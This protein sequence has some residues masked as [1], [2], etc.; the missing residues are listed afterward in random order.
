MHLTHPFYAG[1]KRMKFLSQLKLVEKY[2]VGPLFSSMNGSKP[3]WHTNKEDNSGEY[4]F[5]NRHRGKN[6]KN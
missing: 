3:K 2:W 5:I 6:N 1:G 4:P